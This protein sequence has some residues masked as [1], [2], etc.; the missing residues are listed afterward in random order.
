MVLTIKIRS[1]DVDCKYKNV[2]TAFPASFSTAKLKV[3]VLINFAVEN[4]AKQAIETL[5]IFQ[6]NWFCCNYHKS[7]KR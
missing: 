5:C 3:A 7:K 1:N 6:S 4:D 2:S